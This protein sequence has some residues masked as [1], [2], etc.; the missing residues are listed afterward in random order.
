M[1][2]CDRFLNI[3]EM[4]V[5]QVMMIMI[6]IPRTPL[7]PFFSG[8]DLPF[9]GS[10]LPTYGSFGFK[11]DDNDDDNV[12]TMI[13][14]TK[15]T[16]SD[17]FFLRGFRGF[18]DAQELWWSAKSLGAHVRSALRT[19]VRGTGTVEA[20]RGELAKRRFLQSLAG[21]EEISSMDQSGAF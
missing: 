19:F 16:L 9:Y 3:Y 8:V 5:S 13:L 11:V 17:C 20:L 15:K 4:T 12:M 2:D 14:I 18:T 6:Y 10:T 1:T 21:S 7:T